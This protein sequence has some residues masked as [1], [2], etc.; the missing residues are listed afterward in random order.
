MLLSTNSGFRNP[1]LILEPYQVVAFDAVSMTC[2]YIDHDYS[3]L[4]RNLELFALEKYHETKPHKIFNHAWSFIDNTYKLYGILK[5]LRISDEGDLLNSL[6]LTKPFRN[7]WQHID[8][9]IEYAKNH[10][11]PLYGAISWYYKNHGVFQAISLQSGSL[12]A[13]T[14]ITI[15]AY[16]YDQ[17]KIIQ[18]IM[19]QSFTRGK[20]AYNKRLNISLDSLYNEVAKIIN[21]LS[22]QVDELPLS[23]E[24][25][26]KKHVG[27]AQFRLDL[28]HVKP[29]SK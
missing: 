10:G 11:L 19:F 15:D 4:L 5:S 18:K 26:K 28:E 13:S 1:P 23:D 6:L 27:F 24:L 3:E 16:E 12:R 20:K 21:F 29:Q 9:R 25:M 22:N 8:S 7:T 2:D 14:E 17:D